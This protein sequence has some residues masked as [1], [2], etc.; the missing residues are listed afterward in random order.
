MTCQ[1]FAPNVEQDMEQ[2]TTLGLPA[3]PHPTQTLTQTLDS[4]TANQQ[5]TVIELLC[6][7]MAAK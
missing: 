3:M 1:L 6:T 7:I 2:D 4:P 5:A